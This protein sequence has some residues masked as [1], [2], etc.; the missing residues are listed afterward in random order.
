MILSLLRGMGNGCIATYVQ[1]VW[2]TYFHFIYAL[3]CTY[4]EIFIRMWNQYV[5][6]L[7]ELEA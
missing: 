3:L 2:A 4:W 5:D 1:N 6:I 7:L